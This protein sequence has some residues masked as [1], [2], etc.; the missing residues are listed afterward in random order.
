MAPVPAAAE[1]EAATG[2]FFKGAIYYDAELSQARNR[3]RCVFIDGPAVV[4]ATEG[5]CAD[6]EHRLLQADLDV[7]LASVLFASFD[8][9]TGERM[10]A[11]RR[12]RAAGE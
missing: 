2:P 8:D 7:Y 5:P 12:G 4:R 3:D 10:E 1:I 9:A 11:E 6:G